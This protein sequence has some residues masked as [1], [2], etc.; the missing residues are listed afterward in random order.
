MEELVTEEA[1]TLPF[2]SRFLAGQLEERIRA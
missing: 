1:S 2:M